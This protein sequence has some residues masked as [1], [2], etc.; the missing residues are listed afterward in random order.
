MNDSNDWIVDIDLEKFFD[1]VNHDK[2]MTIIGRTIKDGDV[3]SIVREY[4][5]SGI[6]IDDEYEDSVVGTP[7]GGNGKLKKGDI[8]LVQKLSDEKYVIIE[9]LLEAA[10]EN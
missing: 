1:T 5:V 7:Q 3:I 8:V 10:D 2:L 9:K 6:M 4:L